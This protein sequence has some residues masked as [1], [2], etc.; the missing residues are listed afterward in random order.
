MIKAD[1]NKNLISELKEG[2]K[3]IFI[4]HAYAPGGGDPYNFDISDCDTQRNLSYNGKLQAT[5]IGNL[6]KKNK[7]PIHRVISS[8]WCRCKETAFLSFKNFETK[9]FL[10]SFFSLKF[11]KNRNK[12]MKELKK[13]IEEWQSEGNLVL[14]THYVVILEALG[15]APSSGEIVISNKNLKKIGSIEIDY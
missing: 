14:V 4:R 8:E 3:V 5:K 10:N 15:Y 11:S 1:L 13:Y 7:I 6:F 2:G 12:Q 9:N